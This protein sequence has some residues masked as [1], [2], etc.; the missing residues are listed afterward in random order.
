MKN[1]II[2]LVAAIAVSFGANAQ[3]T[4]PRFGTAAGQ[5]NTYRS[6]TL[7]YVPLSDT[8]GSTP[9]TLTFT[10]GLSPRGATFNN[11]IKVTV[12]DSCVL[13]IRS[14]KSSYFG[15]ML[16]VVLANTAGTN[17]NVKF[18]GYSILATKWNCNAS[19]GT[20]F[21][22]ATGAET[23][24]RFIFDGTAWSEISRSVNN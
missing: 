21:S 16:T 3:S 20:K 14:V 18:L 19:S 11:Y 8:A 2:L 15:D 23:V 10:P 4:T 5:D 22:L 1:V 9:D 12:T 6:L 17:H 24:V 7:G 13:A